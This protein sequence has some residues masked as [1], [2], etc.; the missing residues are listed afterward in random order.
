VICTTSLP[1]AEGRAFARRL[2]RDGFETVIVPD[3]AMARACDEAHLAFVGAD[4]VTEEGVVNK[5][6]TRLLALAAQDAGIGCYAIAPTAKLLP[7]AVWRGVDAPD[8][9]STP[10]ELFDAILTEKGPRR[11]TAIRRAAARVRLN[12]SLMKR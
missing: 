10:L 5:V 7:D 2:E 6:G 9:E 8:Y 4:A 11:P 12:R 1:G 3:A